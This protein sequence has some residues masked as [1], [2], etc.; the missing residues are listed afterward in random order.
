MN[1]H[2]NKIGTICFV[3][4]AFAITASAQIGIKD[5]KIGGKKPDPNKP[6]TT[7]N[8]GNKT[9]PTPNTNTKV[10]PPATNVI[11]AG[12]GATREEVNSFNRD[13]QQFVRERMKTVKG[14]GKGIYLLKNM[15][16][17]AKRGDYTGCGASE[18]NMRLAL[19][20]GAAFAE[21][22]KAKYPSIENPTW[23]NDPESMVGDWRRATE[24][25]N[26]IMKTCITTRLSVELES[27]TRGLE[28][29]LAK[30]KAD[31]KG[32]GEWAGF[33]LALHFDEPAVLHARLADKYKDSF[34]IV[35][36]TMPDDSVF[37]PYD[38]AL[39]NLVDEA[40]K[41]A[42]DWKWYWNHHDAMIETKARGW[43][44]RQ[45]PQGR[46]VKIG[47]MHSDWQ[48]DSVNG[49]VPKGRYKRGYVMYR[50]PGLQQ[51]IVN[52]FSYEQNYM[53]GGRYNEMAV[54][55]GMG[56]ALR[57]QNCN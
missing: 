19:D 53:G 13:L 3:L 46:I 18:T 30:F 14:G 33:I 25:R 15:A 12:G 22:V 1:H 27:K 32:G 17:Q 57:L 44:A 54:T 49:S 38:A 31:P 20:D 23:T 9:P 24:N 48:V 56:N 8:T 40:K 21:I 42:A 5:L 4:L 55:S 28:E 10:T 41:H 47:M 6:P 37:G 50:K 29:K 45:E 26:E 43:F 16:D 2:L 35:G 39:K 34:A 51:C 52:S 36:A 11:G 7:N